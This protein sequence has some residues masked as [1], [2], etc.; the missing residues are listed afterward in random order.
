MSS[1]ISHLFLLDS[2]LRFWLKSHAS[3]ALLLRKWP[4]N[5]MSFRILVIIIKL[6]WA[7]FCHIQS[8]TSSEMCSL[9]LTNLSAHT[10]GA[11]CSRHCGARGAVGVRCLAQVLTSVVDNSCW[12][13]DSNPQPWV[14]SATLYPLEPRLPPTIKGGINECYK[15]FT[16]SDVNNMLANMILVWK[17][18]RANIF[19]VKL[20]PILLL[21]SSDNVTPK[22]VKQ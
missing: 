9:H 8:I 6:L 15:L 7:L 19:C 1:L 17:T 12:S 16:C 4:S 2:K 5:V 18:S 11:V 14:T 22:S 3:Q 13:R 20:Y 10:P 21:W